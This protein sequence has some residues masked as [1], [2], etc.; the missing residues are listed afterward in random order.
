MYIPS[1][2][3]LL[4][5]VTILTEAGVREGMHVADLGC[6]ATG[7]IVF[8]AS[9]MVGKNGIVYGVD[10]LKSALSGVE[11][12]AKL[13]GVANVQTVWSD[14]E[15]YGA[16][17]VPE[18]SLDLATLVN[19]RPSPAMMRETVRLIK[20]GGTLVVVDWVVT[21]TPF[22]PAS[23]ERIDTETVKR[24][25]ADLRLTLTKEFQAGQYH[26]GVIFK[27]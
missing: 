13:E 16:T 18:A 6:G 12:R 15:V 25:A 19:N 5:P 24:M 4:N 23:K 14:I 27:K 22:G 10:I 26:Y 1:G 7:H 8:P 17:K 11:S 20:P 21:A 3:E 9:H 2:S